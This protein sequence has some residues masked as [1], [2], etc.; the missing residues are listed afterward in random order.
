MMNS[1]SVEL[2]EWSARCE[3]AAASAKDENERISLLKKSE[4]LRALADSEDWLTGQPA[5]HGTARMEG[6][7]FLSPDRSGAPG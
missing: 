3:A 5:G 6:S 4:A 2:R 1:N 7:A